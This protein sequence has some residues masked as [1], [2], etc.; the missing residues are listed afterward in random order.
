MA[1]NTCGAAWQHE[2]KSEETESQDYTVGTDTCVWG[3]CK[4]TAFLT[5]LTEWGKTD[6]DNERLSDAEFT[7]KE[8]ELKHYISLAQ[9]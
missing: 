1:L 8:K 9:E 2:G 7:V 4:L 6:N 5:S 3:A